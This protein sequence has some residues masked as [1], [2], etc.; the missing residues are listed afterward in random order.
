MEQRNCF[1]VKVAVVALALIAI[2]SPFGM[3]ALTIAGHRI[4]E[5]LS[6][7]G[8]AAIGSLGTLIVTRRNNGPKD[9]QS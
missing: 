6:A 1:A 4:P 5:A 9:G 3:T 8:G 7:V 2:G